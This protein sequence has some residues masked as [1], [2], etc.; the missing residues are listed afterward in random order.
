MIDNVAVCAISGGCLRYVQVNAALVEGS[1][2]I[3]VGVAISYYFLSHP[4]SL[5]QS[6]NCA[7]SRNNS[8]TTRALSAILSV[9]C[10][11]MDASHAMI[12]V[13]E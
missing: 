10:I 1:S 12:V 7:T 8:L 2:T 11:V 6:S 9:F 3:I 5:N 13:A 4:T